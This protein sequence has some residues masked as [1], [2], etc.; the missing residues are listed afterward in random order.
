MNIHCPAS[1]YETLSADEALRI[2]RRLEF[3]HTPKHASWLNMAE[4]EFSALTRDCLQGRHGDDVALARAISAYE[5][6]RNAAQTT[7]DWRF[8]IQDAHTNSVA[9]IPAI[10]ILI[11]YQDTMVFQLPPLITPLPQPPSFPSSPR[12]SHTSAAYCTTR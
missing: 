9:S 8:S 2:A 10:P 6:R 3:H 5:A 12:S 1:W 4:I 11:Q 7:T